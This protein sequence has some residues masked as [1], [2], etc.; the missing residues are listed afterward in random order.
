MATVLL[1]NRRSEL[2]NKKSKSKLALHNL[3][4]QHSQQRMQVHVVTFQL[5]GSTSVQL[6]SLK[7]PLVMF[8]CPPLALNRPY[9]L[10]QSYMHL[11]LATFI[12]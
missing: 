3:H 9:S 1:Q 10:H 11:T 5:E 6:S 7:G 12:E 2:K 4:L 8:L